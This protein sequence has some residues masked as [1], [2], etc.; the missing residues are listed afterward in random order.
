MIAGFGVQVTA[1]VAW[2]TLI[3][4]VR[5]TGLKFVVSVGVKRTERVW[6]PAMR[7]VPRPGVYVKV[8]GVVD[9]ASS[10]AT[11]RAVP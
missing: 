6:V 4:D 3:A 7:M 9:E 11:E 8:P 5:V 10:W 2:V 1:G